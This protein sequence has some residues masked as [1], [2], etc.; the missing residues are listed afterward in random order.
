MRNA[1]GRGAVAGHAV[2]DVVAV[3]AGVR[4]GNPGDTDAGLTGFAGGSVA[5]LNGDT[6]GLFHNGCACGPVANGEEGDT[7]APVPKD[8]AAFAFEDTACRWPAKES[9]D[10][11]PGTEGL[12]PAGTGPPAADA[13]TDVF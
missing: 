12:A 7:R 4:W 3:D 8:G 11:A 5:R 6:G 13:P 9:A 2:A 1:D 10:A